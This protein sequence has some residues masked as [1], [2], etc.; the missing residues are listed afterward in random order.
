MVSKKCL[1]CNSDFNA[2]GNSR[3]CS[4]CSIRSCKTCEKDF[5][6][7]LKEIKSGREFCSVKCAQSDP[8]TKRKILDSCTKSHGGIGFAGDQ[9]KPERDLSHPE[10]REKIKRTMIEKYGVEN[11][12]QLPD[13]RIKARENKNKK[14]G[15]KLQEIKHDL[16]NRYENMTFEEKVN[17]SQQDRY[18]A[19]KFLDIPEE[20]KKLLKFH[21]Q[22]QATLNNVAN[23]TQ[24]ERDLKIEKQR[25]GIKKYWDSMSP[26][27]R[28]DE[29]AKR[30]NKRTKN[31]LNYK[32]TSKVNQS[33]VKDINN[34]TNKQCLIEQRSSIY[35]FDLLLD[36]I[37]IDI[38]PTCSHNIDTIFPHLVGLCREEDCTKHHSLPNNY[39]N[40]RVDELYKNENNDWLFVYDWMPKENVI[41]TIKNK[42]KST[43]KNNTNY[44]CET[45][46]NQTTTFLKENIISSIP[47]DYELSTIDGNVFVSKDHKD[48]KSAAIITQYKNTNRLII[49]GEEDF[50]F[51]KFCSLHN[52][53]DSIIYL[54]DTN[55]G[56][57][58]W[59]R[60]FSKIDTIFP[61]TISDLTRGFLTGNNTINPV[62]VIPS[63]I[64]IFKIK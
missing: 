4:D 61:E 44:F 26:E 60:E 12:F 24:E 16:E 27:E 1:I 56:P 59:T 43:I 50:D 58:W 40:N 14:S 51:V 19:A 6:I 48:I 32:A 28:S 49:A 57:H 39:H 46:D 7:T 20:E 15:E 34:A 41:N 52:N 53:Y 63:R 21:R 23:M 37:F 10:T 30:R 22:S 29:L 31:G 25:R 36:N 42:L 55:T 3:I 54:S 62:R 5:K 45:L 2:R 35:V 33:W 13:V 17:M 8:D 11:A 9:P 47:E 18:Y 64:E 38:N